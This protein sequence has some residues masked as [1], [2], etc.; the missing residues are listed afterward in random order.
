MG[1]DITTLRVALGVVALTLLLLFYASFRRTRSSYNGWWCIALLFFFSGNLAFLLNGTPH[2]VW[3]NPS[4]NVLLV[5]GAFSVW[6]GARS[7]RKLTPPSWQFAAACGVTAL[8]SALEGPGYNTW[9]GGL[10]YL[11]FMTLGIALASRDLWLLDSSYSHVHKSM[12]L[13]AAFMAAYYFCRLSVYLVEGPT[14]PSFRLYFGPAMASLVTLILLVAVSFSMTALSNDQLINR[15]S[16]RAARDNLTGLLNRGTF[17]ELATKELKRLHATSSVASLILADMDHFKSINDEHGHPAG[18]AALQAF[19]A[20]CTES[21]RSTDLVGR[22]GGEEFILLLPGANQ[23]RAESIAADIS[24]ALAETK[25]LPGIQIPTASYGVTAS[26]LNGVDLSAMIAAADAA[27][28][29][30]KS[31]GRNRV[32]GAAPNAGFAAR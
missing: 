11:G 9:S 3:A 26:S 28:Y 27:L 24:R 12:A 6:T 21:V 23:E 30:A 8:A 4:G 31:L 16:E 1:L 15:L 13:A 10:V 14:G 7:L 18:D 2:Q 20:A 5:G 22:Y 17:L 25:S 19:A 32:V 29:Q